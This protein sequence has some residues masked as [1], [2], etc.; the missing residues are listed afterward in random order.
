M[1]S[2]AGEAAIRRDLLDHARRALAGRYTI[3]REVGRGGAARVFSALTP[4]GR[5]VA[6]KILHPEL[7]VSVTADRFLREVRLLAEMDHPR[8]A[9]MLDYGE[10]EFLI[11]Y[12]MDFIEGPTLRDHLLRARR[13]TIGDT[14]RIARDLLEA[15]DYAHGRGIVHRDVKPEN[16][17]LAPE[18][19]ML[20]DF[21]VAR[22]IA[23]SGSE[24]LTRSGFTVGTSAYMSPEQVTGEQ[25]ID[26]RGDI[27]S[28]G[29][30]L[31]ECLAGRPPFTHPI[32]EL[33]LQMQR[34]AVPPEVTTFR[35][36]TPPELAAA[37]HR[38]IAKAR[39]DRWQSAAEMAAAL[40]WS[41]P[42]ASA[43]S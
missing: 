39:A 6:L 25:D 20:M 21:G 22:A 19:A 17:V 31:F 8:I 33:V 30:V 42:A 32:E 5:A 24:R 27:Y 29:C 37:I 43:R 10:S 28:L 7:V 12:V 26:Q 35:G 15:L 9:R 18:G 11:Y 40:G 23:T 14:L 13:A 34:E 1:K 41:T 38:S 4:D 36:D 16:I 3:D 2:R